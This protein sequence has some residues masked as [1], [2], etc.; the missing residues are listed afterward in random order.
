MTLP[1]VTGATVLAES[2]SFIT[3]LDHFPFGTVASIFGIIAF[4]GLS[5]W[6]WRWSTRRLLKIK[7]LRPIKAWAQRIGDQFDREKAR[8]RRIEKFLTGWETVAKTMASFST[9]YRNPDA[10]YNAFEDITNREAKEYKKRLMAVIDE[11]RRNG[12]LA[13]ET[14][15]Y[16]VGTINTENKQVDSFFY[17]LSN[18]STKPDG[19]VKTEPQKKDASGN[20]TTVAAN[21][22]GFDPQSQYFK[23]DKR[24][25]YTV[26]II[27]DHQK[28]DV[29]VEF[30]VTAEFIEKLQ[31]LYGKVYG[32]D[33]TATPNPKS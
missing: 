18:G 28:Q 16:A 22:V 4:I 15:Q 10:I 2:A 3:A 33:F 24:Y 25:T 30:N 7:S 14:T 27:D 21:A 12:A 23:P 6:T 11:F 9:E 29:R 1:A 32:R 31:N 17:N 13:L 5:I 8:H 19:A 26:Y 20:Y